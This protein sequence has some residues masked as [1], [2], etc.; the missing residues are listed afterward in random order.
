M[1]SENFATAIIA[2]SSVVVMQLGIM[3][4]LLMCI[5]DKL[6]RRDQPPTDT[7]DW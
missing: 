4:V 7:T 5:N 2:A 1:S 3:V 6:K